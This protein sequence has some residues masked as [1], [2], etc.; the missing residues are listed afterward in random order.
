MVRQPVGIRSLAIS[1]PSVI[2]TNDYFRENY[3]DLVEGAE[4]KSLARAFSP[5]ESNCD[6]ESDIWTREMM[7][8]LADPFRGTIERRVLGDGESALTLEYQAARDALAAAELDT[9]EVDLMIVVS[10]FPEQLSPGNAAFLAGQLELNCGAWNLESTCTSSIVGLQT[11]SSLIRTG[12]YRN[13]LVV[14]STTFSQ[15]TDE[16]D[17]LSF[18][19]GDAA[20]AFVVGSLQEG[21]GLLSTKL[22]HTA[23]TCDAFFGELGFDDDRNPRFFIRAGKNA[24]RRM[25]DEFVKKCRQ[26]CFEALAAANATLEDVDFFI[27]NTNTAWYSPVYIHALGIDPERTINLNPKYGNIGAPS[28]LVNLYHA[29]QAKKIQPNDLVLMYAFGGTS[30]AG[31]NV[32]RWGEVALA[33]APVTAAPMER[34][35]VGV[36]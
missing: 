2:R 28:P 9:S 24:N 7:P 10:L 1:C 19:V 30:N 6:L 26:C 22:V 5:V 13:V 25:R 20:A 15:Y 3:A 16:R 14:L 31:A 11:A 8:Y 17:T 12:E 29:V 18:L 32:M 33:P 23:A 27:F 21:Q 4:Q 36:S 35:L 34:V